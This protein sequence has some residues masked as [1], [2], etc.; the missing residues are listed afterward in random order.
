MK[1]YILIL[2]I[3]LGF[4]SC[5]IYRQ[6]VV[7]VPLMQQKGQTQISGHIGFNGYD[8]Q[9]GYALTNNIAVIA[10]YNNLGIKR[11]GSSTNYSIDKHSFAEIGAGYYKKNKKE[12]LTEFF[13]VAG[14]GMTS[15]FVTGGDT[16]VGHTPLFADF[17]KVYYNRFLIQ[18]DFGKLHGK[19]EYAFSPRIFF[20]N[21]YNIE[22]NATDEYKHVSSSYLYSDIALTT[23]YNF[24]KYFKIS[25]Q[26][27]LTIPLTGYKVAYYEASPINGSIGL[28]INM[29]FFRPDDKKKE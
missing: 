5:G 29:N 25:G 12:L 22:D 18:A 28:I 13:L 8:G 10:N 24:A 9:A 7:N 16:I 17:R 4:S 27:S 15:R 14:N 19:F 20:I 3:G 23:R 6:N 26:V 1:K 11:D 2:I 21:Y